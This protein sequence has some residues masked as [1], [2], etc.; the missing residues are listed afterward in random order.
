ME[1]RFRRRHRS[2]RLTRSGLLF[3]LAVVAIGAVAV[4][5]GN[6]LLYLTFSVL[7]SA[8][9]SQG[10]Y[11]SQIFSISTSRSKTRRTVYCR[12]ARKG[13]SAGA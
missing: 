5:S 1:V 9:I 8:L 3:F 4:N 6:N 7:L 11:P 10:C 2:E 13:R 12:P